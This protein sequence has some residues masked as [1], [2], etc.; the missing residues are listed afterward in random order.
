MGMARYIYIF[1]YADGAKPMFAPSVLF[2]VMYAMQEA[3]LE[4]FHHMVG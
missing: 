1:I 3:S 4:D 2:V